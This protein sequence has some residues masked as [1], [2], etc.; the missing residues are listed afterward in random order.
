VR[1]LFTTAEA[2]ETGLTAE[3]LRWGSH[4]GRFRS[5][6]RDV[7]GDGPHEPSALD[8]ARA[9][10]LRR[11]SEARGRLAGVLHELDSVRLDG[12]PTRRDRLPA[13]WTV[14]VGGQP[15][16]D[17]LHTL[18]DLAAVLDDLRWE[19]ALESALRKGLMS[20]ADIERALPALGRS[21]V[22]GTGRVRR[23]LTLRPPGA[24]PTE[25]LLETFAVQLARDV[26]EVGELARQY[27]V[28]DEDGLFI[29]RLDL[30]KPEIGFF[31]ELDGEQHKGQPV[32]DAM[33]ETAVVAATGWL[34]GRFTWTEATRYPN[35]TKRRMAAIATQ[36]RCRWTTR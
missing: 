31:F 3:A 9:N 32:Y 13:E 2:R 14:M 19:Q 10:V 5:I 11:H 35:A 28:R 8:W 33:R 23:V 4:V 30:C 20:I 7:Y 17:G 18:I 12:R 34:P 22:P 24:L 21:R 15:C 36:A 16:A 26:P 6:G 29:A 27:V 25:S 1:H